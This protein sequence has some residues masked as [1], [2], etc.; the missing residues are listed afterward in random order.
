MA[1]YDPQDIK[2]KT[3]HGFTLFEL[4]VVIAIISVSFAVFLTINFSFGSPEDRIRKEADRLHLLLSFAHEQS[5]IRAEEYGLRFH[6]Q[7]YKFMQYLTEEDSWVDIDDKILGA[8][9]LP[10]DL[11][12]ELAIE[13]VDIILDD[14]PDPADNDDPETKIKPQVFL[15]S[16]GETTPDFIVRLSIPGIDVSFEVHGTT[17]GK[18]ALKKSE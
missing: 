5:V 12:L 14:Q 6:Q 2:I 8:K 7:G 15:L 16:S 17:D 18:Y 1:T 10:E 9:Q 11:E 3:A 4:L 13:Q